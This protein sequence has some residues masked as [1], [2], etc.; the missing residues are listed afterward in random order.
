MEY[1][2]GLLGKIIDPENC[3]HETQFSKWQQVF[4][5]IA[6]N[7]IVPDKRS[8]F[9]EEG[10]ER[11]SFVC[12]AKQNGIAVITADY[13]HC[14]DNKLRILVNKTPVEWRGEPVRVVLFA[15]RRHMPYDDGRI[16]Q[17]IY[18]HLLRAGVGVADQV[19]TMSIE[20]LVRWCA[21]NRVNR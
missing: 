21:Y 18:S 1:F 19:A 9:I 12:C 16:A 13:E 8:A 4:D 2:S 7:F 14:R 20:E 6:D 3:K 5:Y 11:N 17:D 10:L 15:P